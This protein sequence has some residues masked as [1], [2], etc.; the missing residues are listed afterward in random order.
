[1]YICDKENL[2]IINPI[3]EQIYKNFDVILFNEQH[4]KGYFIAYLIV[5]GE[6]SLYTNCH[7]TFNMKSKLYRMILSVS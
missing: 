5:S 2:K 3:Y 1:M 4:M 6:H 7:Q